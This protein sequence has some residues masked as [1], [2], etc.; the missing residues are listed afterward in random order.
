[1]SCNQSKRR[2]GRILLQE[3]NIDDDSPIIRFGTDNS[4]LCEAYKDEY[5][6]TMAKNVEDKIRMDYHCRIIVISNYWEEHCAVYY[7]AGVIIVP[8]SNYIN[9][10]LFFYDGKYK[11]DLVYARLNVKFV[12]KFWMEKQAL[13]MDI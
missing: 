1:M 13:K 11:K 5:Q 8:Q 7:S 10:K 2:G 9:K 6:D 12:V 4:E 3:R